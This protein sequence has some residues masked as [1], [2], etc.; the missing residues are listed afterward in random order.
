[1]TKRVEVEGLGGLLKVK[2]L[3]VNKCWL[4]RRRKTADYRRYEE[5]VGKLLRGSHLCW[6]KGRLT[7][8]LTF[9]FSSDASDIDNPVKP[10][11]DILQKA[12]AFNDKRIYRLVVTKVLVNKGSE[13]IS[14]LLEPY[15]EEDQC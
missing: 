4:G 6:P 8:S 15:I 7:L 1:M 5:E 9:G 10:I 14:Y 2:P 13:F 3:S 12:L 11:Q